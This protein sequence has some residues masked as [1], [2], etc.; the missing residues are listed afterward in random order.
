MK[1][2]LNEYGRKFFNKRPNIYLF[3]ILI[4]ILFFIGSDPENIIINFIK[5]FT[6]ILNIF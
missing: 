3:I 2:I 5:Y 4:T 6:D 1:N